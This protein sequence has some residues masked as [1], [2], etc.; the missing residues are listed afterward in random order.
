[1]AIDKISAFYF[2]LTNEGKVVVC[3]FSELKLILT[4]ITLKQEIISNII[5]FL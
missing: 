4:N 3:T 2:T 5:H 1:M